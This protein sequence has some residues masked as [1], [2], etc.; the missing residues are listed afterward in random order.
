M[1]ASGFMTQPY[2]PTYPGMASA[3]VRITKRPI[4]DMERNFAVGAYK[5]FQK[6]V[7]VIAI[8]P[9]VLFFINYLLISRNSDLAI[10]SFVFGIINI[11]VAFVAI[12]MA[13]SLLVTRKKIAQIMSGGSV[14]EV[15]GNAIRGRTTRN[16]PS[17]NVGPVSIFVTPEVSRLVVEG[18][19]VSVVCI[20]QLKAALSINNAGLSRGARI[21]CPPNIEMMALQGPQPQQ[22]QQPM[23]APQP[24]SP[25]YYPQAA[26]QAAPSQPSYPQ[27]TPAMGKCPN[28]GQ[29]VQP[30]WQTCAFC[31]AR[32][33]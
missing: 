18:A 14:I 5:T 29:L 7:R 17:F 31:N 2:Q 28:C 6:S 9:L 27:Y 22:M 21:T 32:L 12:G 20:P 1:K 33:K 11:V 13:I 23:I 4:T 25:Q 10:M 8:V 24:A 30:H 26:P 15:Q 16:M 19:P 3:P